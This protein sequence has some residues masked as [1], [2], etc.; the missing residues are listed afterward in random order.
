MPLADPLA[1]VVDRLNLI[2]EHARNEDSRMAYFAVLYRLTTEALQAAAMNGRFDD[3][4]RLGQFTSTFASRYFDALDAFRRNDTHA[5]CWTVAFR[6]T[7]SWRPIVV[8]HLILGMNAHINYD[9]AIAAAVTAPGAEL[10]RLGRDFAAVNDIFGGLI[11][12]VGDALA[13]IWPS[14]R[15]LDALGGRTD[16]KIINY[17]IRRARAAAWAAAQQLAALDGDAQKIEL[18]RLD[19]ETHAVAQKILSPGLKLSLALLLVRAQERGDVASIVDQLER[20][21]EVDGFLRS[22]G[23]GPF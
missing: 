15:L 22:I 16:E 14:L 17:S 21:P 20:A 8:Q 10:P 6:A 9:L 11:D 18:H 3:P 13:R 1:D 5:L 12:R 7:A 2:V 19:V 23:S 4:V